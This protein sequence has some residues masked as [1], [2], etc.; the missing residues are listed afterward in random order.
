M[1]RAILLLL[2]A[3]LFTPVIGIITPVGANP[4]GENWLSGYSYRKQIT[5]NGTSAGAQTDY[6]MELGIHKN[7]PPMATNGMCRPIYSNTYPQAYYYNGNTYVVWQGA[8]LDPYI[9]AY[10][11]STQTWH[12]AIKVGDNPISG[13]F[14]GAPSVIVDNSGYIHVFFGC[15]ASGYPVIK[16]S[17]SNSA[18]DISAWTAQAEISLTSGATYPQVIKDTDGY[19]WL[20]ARDYVDYGASVNAPEVYRKSEDDG[21]TW[22]AVAT[23]IEADEVPNEGIYMGNPEYDSVNGLIHV[24]WTYQQTDPSTLRINLY[25]AYLK[26]SDGHMYSMGGTDLGT[27][28]TTTEADTYCKIVTTTGTDQIGYHPKLH[29]DSNGYPYIIYVFFV[30]ADTS[31]YFIRWSGSSWESPIQIGSGTASGES[32][33]T[34]TASNDISAYFH[35]SHSLEKWHW[36]GSAWSQETTIMPSSAFQEDGVSQ[37][38]EVLDGSELK[39]IFSDQDNDDFTNSDL[40]V[41]VLDSGDKLIP[42]LGRIGLNGNCQDDFDD[43]RFTQ[44]DGETELD[45]WRKSYNS[46]DDAIFWVEFNSI[47]ASPSSGIFYI[48]YSD[49]GASS[50]SSEPDTFLQ[51]DDFEWGNDEDD[52]STDGGYIDW[53]IVAGGTSTVKID[54]AYS[55]SGTRSARL[56]RDGTNTPSARISQVAA[57][58]TIGLWLRLDSTSAFRFWHGDGA[59]RILFQHDGA[60]RELQ[61]FDGVVYTGTGI[62]I[63]REQWTQLR[64]TNIDWSGGTYD[65]YQ[66]ETVVHC[67]MGTTTGS[68]DLI[69]FQQV[70][71]S[72]SLWIDDVVVRQWCDPEPTWGEWGEEEAACSPSI[73]LNTSSWDVNSGDPVSEASTYNAGLTFFTIT[74]NSGGPVNISISGIDMT[75]GGHTWTLSDTATPGDMTYGLKAGLSGGDYTIIVKKNSP[76]NSLVED[77]ADEA[78]QDWGL[79]IYTP[80]NFDDGNEKSGTITLT[81]VCS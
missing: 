19:L 1:K 3:I 41:Y 51:W 75:G 32:A 44:S 21:A 28:I 64:V 62:Y 38:N 61:Y 67:T 46:G 43:I 2:I 77:L 18:E 12:G 34:I 25:H 79:K 26:I 40:E 17:K 56:S 15:H 81:V 45:H 60:T 68:A 69:I 48:Y 53:D 7:Y 36:N 29:L 33:F 52:L 37:C 9:D 10:N 76:Y 24:S 31:T 23:I 57:E 66:D 42:G 70:Y 47:P 30:D 54:T 27:S 74:N 35:S 71:G 58:Y 13:G 4:D 6:Q 55:Y 59:K 73:D 39:I 11:H 49:I 78:T 5:I 50:N 80:T 22:S 16:H 63:T 14:H 65:I 8:G 20:F 72:A